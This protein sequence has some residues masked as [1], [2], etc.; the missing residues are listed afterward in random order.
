[1]TTGRLLRHLARLW[2]GRRRDRAFRRE[3]RFLPFTAIL[4]LEPRL[5][6]STTGTPAPVVM[7]GATTVDSRSV[8][9]DYR[10]D[11]APEPLAPLS[12]GVYRSSD[13]GFGPGA[14]LLGTWTV[15]TGGSGQ[16]GMALDDSGQAASAPGTH[17]L[18]IPLAVGLPPFPSKPYVLVVA[19]PDQTSAVTNPDQTASFRTYV[20]G[21]VTHGAMINPSWKHGPPWQ[22]Q[23]ATLLK[24]QGYDAVI[25]FNWVTESSKPGH[26]AMQGPRLARQILATASRFPASAPVDLHF[27]GHSEGAVVNTQAIIALDKSMT[28]Q[29]ASGWVEDTLLDPHAASNAVPDQASAGSGLFGS[30]ATAIVKDYQARANDPPVFIPA[31]VDAAQVFYQHTPASHD[32]GVNQGLYN[33]WGQVPVP[34]L[35]GHPVAYYNLTDAGATHSGNYG[36]SLWYRN[37]V[38]PTLG[39]QASLIRSLQLTGHVDQ[40]VPAAAPSLSA[41][42]LRRVRAWGPVQLVATPRAEFSG[43]AAPGSKV[44]VYLG[45]ASDL[46]TI[47]PAVQ[48]TADASGAWSLT[49][50]P[51]HDGRY[52]GIAMAFLPSSR[53]R[54]GL[55]IVPMAPLGGFTVTAP[56]RG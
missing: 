46:S 51:L 6:L 36:V 54:P 52:R 43:T 49:T 23:T 13:P 44:R 14:S 30:L 55:T 38:A 7:L 1:M 41:L 40:A 35:S 21:I 42:A 15:A 29:L 28:P 17:R 8:A 19:D 10:I 27:I 16:G 50:R 32:H 56:S 18:T 48:T 20:I 37:F 34:N 24:R 47:A 4:P 39:N 53:T 2:P 11:Q 25:P 31:G 22:L 26:A 9:I 45:P 33:L 3:P 12:F 5:V